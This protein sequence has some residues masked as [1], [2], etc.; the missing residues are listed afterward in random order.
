MVV[1]LMTLVMACSQTYN[2]GSMQLV[3]VHQLA[4]LSLQ[5]NA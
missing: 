3:K 4:S 2:I 5:G 1:L